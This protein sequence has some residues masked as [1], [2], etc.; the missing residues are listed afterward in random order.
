MGRKIFIS[1][2]YS[3]SSVYPLNDNYFTTARHYVD[4]LQSKLKEDDHI[5]KG[6]AD[7]EDLSDFKDETIWT[8]LKDKIFDS[9]LTIIFISKNM[10]SLFDR[11]ENQW[12][13]WEISYSLK[14]LTRDGRTSGTNAL[15]A[16]VLPDQNNGYEYFI[17]DNSCPYCNCRTLKTNTL[18]TILRENMFNI[19]SP[20]YNDCSNHSE[21]NKVYTGE[22]SYIRSVKWVDFINKIDSY[23]QIAYDIN[24]NIDKYNIRKSV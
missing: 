18:F 7:G 22:H 9:T 19:K 1:Y 15:L 10:K 21:G 4:E 23:L 14:E 11:E 5:N 3:D 6:E 12:I 16:V 24:E 13:P 2:K 20:I 8:K 17:Q